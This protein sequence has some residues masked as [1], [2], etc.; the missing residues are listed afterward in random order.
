MPLRFPHTLV[1]DRNS[2]DARMRLGHD[3]RPL[4]R[5]SALGKAKRLSR[6]CPV[7][8]ELFLVVCF[9]SR[10]EVIRDSVADDLTYMVQRRDGRRCDAPMPASCTANPAS[11][12]LQTISDS[13]RIFA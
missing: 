12:C 6:P 2:S 9:L 10:M 11:S 3:C 8:R 13:S 4:S 5:T 1:P 7:F